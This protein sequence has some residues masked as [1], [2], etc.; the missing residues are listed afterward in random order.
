MAETSPARQSF[1]DALA[2]L[3]VKLPLNM[4][5]DDIGAVAD[6][7]GRLVFSVDSNRERSDAEVE[8]ICHWI[9]LACNT[10]GGFLAKYVPADGDDAGGP[11]HG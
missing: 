3:N 7:D 8:Q 11:S 4:D 10:C 9:I 6:A 1:R 5:H 2:K